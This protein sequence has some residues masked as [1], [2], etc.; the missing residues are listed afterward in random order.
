MRIVFL[1]ALYPPYIVGGNEIIT[2][3]AVEALRARGHDV[4]VLTA[5]GRQLND[6]DHVHQ[7]FNYD[8]EDKDAIFL[9][10]RKPSPVEL[11]RRHMFDLST[12][13]AVRKAIRQLQPDLVVVDNLYMASAAPLVA[14]RDAPCPVVAQVMDKWLVYYLVDWGMII[15]PQSLLQKLGVAVV[16]DTCQ[17]LIASRVRLNGIATVSDFI[18]DFYVQHG[19]DPTLMQAIYLGFDPAVFRPGPAHPLYDPVRLMFAGGLWEGKGPQVIIQA[20][21]ILQQMG[22]LPRFHLDIYGDGTE[23][24]KQHLR[25]VAVQ[26]GVEGQITL[27]GFV[28][29]DAL[30]AAMHQSD[31]FVFSSI[32][33]EPFATVPLQAIASGLPLVATRAGGTPEGFADGETAL[34]IPPNDPQAMAGAIARLVRDE[35]LCIRLRE[36][37]VR[38]AHERWTFSAYVDRLEGFCRRITE[39]SQQGI[40]GKALR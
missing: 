4:Q 32:W 24:F 23:E 22:G 21:Q 20:L 28:P 29:W 35:A 26:A 8:L 38:T 17:R 27:H 15:H 25:Q 1:I 3:G 13:R 30:A 2:H 9:G 16:R 34:L 18:R 40:Q 7:V 14:V 37:G 36:N 39:Y 6:L 5:H 31:I 10:G 19:F 33:D 12:Y 11:L